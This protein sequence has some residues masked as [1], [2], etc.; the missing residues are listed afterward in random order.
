MNHFADILHAL[1]QRR[2][3]SVKKSLLLAEEDILIFCLKYLAYYLDMFQEHQFKRYYLGEIIT[4]MIA[5][6][7]NLYRRNFKLMPV[8]GGD[9]IEYFDNLLA[10]S[11][12]GIKDS[13]CEIMR[14][15]LLKK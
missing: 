9:I 12:D 1:N 15:L 3:L 5:T 7:A 10:I 6:L 14:A 4:I 8:R 11:S 2:D 13:L